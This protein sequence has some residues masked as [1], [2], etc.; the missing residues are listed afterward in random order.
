MNE[1]VFPGNIFARKQLNILDLILFALILVTLILKFHL[2]F[3]LNI[4]EDEFSF[5]SSV[6]R[7]L[8]GTLSHP[9]FSFH[10]HIF[11]WLPLAAK[12]E[13]G[14]IFAARTFMYFLGLGS[15]AFLY[16]IGKLFFIRSG[17]LFSVL[18]YLSISNVI[19]HGTSFRFD[20]ICVFLFLCTTYCLLKKPRSL[21]SVIMAGLSTGLT[22]MIS[23]KAVLYF[24]TIAAILLIQFF[25]DGNHRSRLKDTLL[26]LVAFISG[27]ILLYQIHLLTLNNPG[28]SPMNTVAGN[29]MSE[30]ILFKEFFPNW[31]YLLMLIIENPL[32]F[33][34]FTSA[35]VILIWDFV[36]SKFQRL[37]ET[38]LLLSLFLPLLSLP[39]YRYNYPY[40][41]VFVLSSAIVVTAVFAAKI[42]GA[43][44]KK[45]AIGYLMLIYFFSFSAFSGF[46]LHYKRNNFDQTISQKEIVALVHKL[47]REPVPYIDRCSMISSFPQ[48]GLRMTSKDME[49]YQ[50]AQKPIMRNLLIQKKPVFIVANSVHLDLSV[51][52]G[53]KKEIS[54][55]YPLLKEDY[56]I[57]KDNFIHHWGAIFVAGKYFSF[58]ARTSAQAFKILVPGVYTIESENDVSINDVAYKPGS[59]IE[60][61]PKTYS[62]TSK[63]VPQHVTLRWGKDL[64]KP[65]QKPSAQPIFLGYYLQALNRP[66]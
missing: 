64:H 25:G 3:L 20:P 2:I 4:D 21:L 24:P 16:L 58:D 40:F 62:I 56:N 45:G 38:L 61:E 59:K 34:I 35:F 60:L 1:T 8:Q 36:T 17:A 12:D 33:I 7:Y 54:K 63:T 31:I 15:C 5:L 41:Y 13:V 55:S 37:S 65:S 57:L 23:L 6:H 26:F 50:K 52:R 48:A 51:P 22:L 39:F 66:H 42:S 43:F 28:S 32:I 10:V 47:F 49:R 14:Q 27:F 44:Y 53:T 30:G 19:V 11:G 18:C 46:L 9:F 29:V